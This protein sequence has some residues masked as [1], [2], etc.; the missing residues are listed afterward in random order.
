MRDDTHQNFFLHQMFHLQN[1]REAGHMISFTAPLK[2]PVGC[3]NAFLTLQGL[4]ATAYVNIR[5]V[6][7]VVKRLDLSG[8]SIN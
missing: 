2:V 6:T 8:C 4:T 5:C 1:S 3:W 7:T